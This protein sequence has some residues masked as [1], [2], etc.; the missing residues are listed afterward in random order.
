[1]AAAG[2][3]WL[4]A[5]AAP[6]RP[7]ERGELALHTP[8]HFSFI[9]RGTGSREDTYR[10]A[11]K[12]IASFATVEHFW[13]VYNHMIRPNHLPPPTDLFLF[14]HGIQP[15]WEDE[16]NASG[17][18]LVLRVRKTATARAFE[19]LALCL[20]GEQFESPDLVCGIACSVRFQDDVLAIWLR[21]G[22]SQSAI[23]SITATAKRA[24]DLST[25][26]ISRPWEFRWHNPA[27]AP[28]SNGE[29]HPA[30]S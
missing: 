11:I 30:P 4:A 8:F 2:K 1:M 25:G 10:T 9:R 14:R 3:S 24:L 12:E 19:D 5:A 20:I 16:T 13:S 29:A 28:A 15:M 21:S 27:S 18:R 6:V 26:A 23:Q 22:D 17:G 7:K